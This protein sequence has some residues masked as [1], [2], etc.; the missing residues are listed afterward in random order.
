MLPG[1][2]G[3]AGSGMGSE[4]RWHVVLLPGTDICEWGRPGGLLLCST[5]PSLSWRGEA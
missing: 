1:T 3:L 2:L 5:L 4:L